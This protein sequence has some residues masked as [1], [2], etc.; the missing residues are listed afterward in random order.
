M[1]ND[2]Q[3]YIQ[4]SELVNTA[5]EGIGETVTASVKGAFEWK[6]EDD[7]VIR[8]SFEVPDVYD[9]KSP[10]FGLLS[11]QHWVQVQNNNDPHPKEAWCSTCDDCVELF[12][13]QN[14]FVRTVPFSPTLNVAFIQTVPSMERFSQTL[15]AVVGLLVMELLLIHDPCQSMSLFW[16]IGY[17]SSC[18]LQG[19]ASPYMRKRHRKL[20][21]HKRWC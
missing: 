20:L 2:M 3:D 9:N 19:R 15:W 4:P 5:V 10:L 14:A 7:S 21:P 6:I 18:L 17:V 8:L 11:P 16:M 13:K 12:W 1:A